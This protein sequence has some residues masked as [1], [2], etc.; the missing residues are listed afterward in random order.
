MTLRSQRNGPCPTLRPALAP[1]SPRLAQRRKLYGWIPTRGPSSPSLLLTV[2][3]D[4][5]P[6]DSPVARCQLV[7]NQTGRDR[8]PPVL[9]GSDR[10]LSAQVLRNLR[11]GDRGRTGDLVLGNCPPTG[12]HSI[13]Q[14]R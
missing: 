9:S 6:T 2:R 1:P 12:S 7:A 14:H 11:A 8:P 13:P 5:L 3:N 4:P 10:S